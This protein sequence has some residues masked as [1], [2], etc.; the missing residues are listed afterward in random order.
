MSAA[1]ESNPAGGATSEAKDSG[2]VRRLV[3]GTVISD[4]RD[5]TRT[6]AVQYQMRHSKYGKYLQRQAKYHVHDPNNQSK[7]G[8]RVQIAPCRPISKNKAWRL[9]RVV[10]S[11]PEPTKT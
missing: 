8:D 3:L 7:T 4:K 5:K 9:V 1:P 10:E 6:V 11:A 2:K